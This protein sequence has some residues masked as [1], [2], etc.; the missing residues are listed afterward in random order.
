MNGTVA[1]NTVLIIRNF[2]GNGTIVEVN[3]NAPNLRAFWINNHD[4]ADD[5]I[6]T[7]CE[8]NQGESIHVI[9]NNRRNVILYNNSA[10]AHDY[11]ISFYVAG[12]PL[13]AMSAT[14]GF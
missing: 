10:E 7:D 3:L 5:E 2:W 6:S 13:G 11:D 14:S 1:A 12:L 9:A 4:E 8:I